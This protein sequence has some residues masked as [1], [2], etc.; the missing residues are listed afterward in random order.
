MKL[1][2][3]ITIT[4]IIKKSEVYHITRMKPVTMWAVDVRCFLF[5]QG[6]N[7]M[8]GNILQYSLINIRN[9]YL[10]NINFAASLIRV[11]VLNV[12]L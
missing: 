11:N 1:I 9:L 7:E 8:L 12:N 4:V 5:A 2:G 6:V 3:N 10:T